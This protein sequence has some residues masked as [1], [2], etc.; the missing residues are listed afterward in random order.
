M[1]K[2]HVIV[3]AD[4]ADAKFFEQTRHA[5]APRLIHELDN[6]MGRRRA[7][8]IMTDRM[9]YR[10]NHPSNWQQAVPQQTD[11]VEVEEER[12]AR[13]IAAYMQDLVDDGRCSTFSLFTPPQLLGR[14][15]KH[16]SKRVEDRVIQEEATEL[17][18]VPTSQLV[19]R[20]REMI[21]PRPIR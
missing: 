20:L 2:P 17:K 12:F 15:R 19:E 11:P 4:A 10:G 13:Q 9:G 8:D 5:D 16:L 14:L 7:R 3:V 21:P 18:N 1:P 6:P